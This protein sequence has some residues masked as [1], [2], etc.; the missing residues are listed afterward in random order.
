MKKSTQHFEEIKTA[1]KEKAFERV[2]EIA[3]QALASLSAS[4]PESSYTGSSKLSESVE[5]Y[6]WHIKTQAYLGLEDYKAVIAACNEILDRFGDNDELELH[7][8]VAAALLDKGNAQEELGDFE[9][10]I[11]AYDEIIKRFSDNNAPE[12][13]SWVASALVK[14]D[15]RK[16][17]GDF[18]T[19][20][21]PTR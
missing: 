13:Q 15:A 17:L 16:E 8:Y 3:D 14:G 19:E 6:L 5:A 12:L 11:E 9:A 10:A 2:I 1:L 4:L 21:R 7:W 20:L 18:E